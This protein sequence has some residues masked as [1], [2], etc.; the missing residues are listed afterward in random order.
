[1]AND[2]HVQ[3]VQQALS[4]TMQISCTVA[5]LDHAELQPNVGMGLLVVEYPKSRICALEYPN[6]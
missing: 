5:N 4:I 1:M 3:H 6:K 2:V